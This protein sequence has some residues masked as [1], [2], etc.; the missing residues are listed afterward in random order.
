MYVYHPY[1][2]SH[3]CVCV[4]MSVVHI[5]KCITYQY[6]CTYMLGPYATVSYVCVT[7]SLTS[8]VLLL[9]FVY[10]GCI[11]MYE[12]MSVNVNVCVNIA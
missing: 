9:L 10:Y 6:E 11:N 5:A 1:V 4:Y 12:Y 2:Y 3:V 8:R 7:H